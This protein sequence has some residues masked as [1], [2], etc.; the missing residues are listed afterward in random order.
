MISVMSISEELH[1]K[2]THFHAMKCLFQSVFTNETA[3]DKQPA[4]R[5]CPPMQIP[6]INIT[7]PGVLKLQQNLN[8]GN[9]S[10]PDGIPLWY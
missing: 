7:L 9:A 10:G 4:Q 8:P 2:I 1:L 5:N 6:H 3:F